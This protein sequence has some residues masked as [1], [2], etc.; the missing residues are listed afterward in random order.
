MKYWKQVVSLV[1]AAAL[2]LF[3]VYGVYYQGYFWYFNID[4]SYNPGELAVAFGMPA[5]V[6][7]IGLA[8]LFPALYSLPMGK[9][10]RHVTWAFIVVVLLAL[11]FTASHWSA[12][13]Y[14][15]RT[16]PEFVAITQ[17]EDGRTRCITQDRPLSLLTY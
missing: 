14:F 8:I 10:T 17:L 15:Q 9:L 2:I 1:F 7:V 12:R 16:S 6:L 11:I 5:G 13:Q 4:T 3:G